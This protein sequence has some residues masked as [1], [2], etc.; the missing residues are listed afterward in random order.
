MKILMPIIK[1]LKTK[2]AICHTEGN[3][4]EIY[5]ANFDSETFT[6]DVFLKRRTSET[7]HYSIVKCNKCGLVRS[8]PVIDAGIIS[9]LY[10]E[11]KSGY[12]HE[13]D[14][15]R[16][17]YRNYL[18]KIEKYNNKKG[19]LLEIGCG[20]G[21][22]L[23]EALALGYRAV[24]GVEPSSATVESAGPKVRSNIICD[25][26]RPGLFSPEQFDIICM[27]H[28]FDHIPDPGILLNECFKILKPGGLIFFLNHNVEAV[29]AKLLKDRSPIINIEHTYLYSFKTIKLIAEKYGFK[30]KEVGKVFNRFKLSYLFQLA[31]I[32][33]KIQDKILSFLKKSRLGNVV[34]SL[35]IGN[36]YLIAQKPE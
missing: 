20:N 21:F 10:S 36:L 25:I 28:L 11:R 6:P 16:V 14:N 35:P 17:T 5:P 8:D 33:F 34:F 19:A 13:I 26:M 24:K 30:A 4:S 18:L 29:S 27:F 32:P 23:E 2:C 12:I 22:F 31:P 1:L 3:A 9:K 7:I 15:R